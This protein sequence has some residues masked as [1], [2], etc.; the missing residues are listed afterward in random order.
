M[1]SF[2]HFDSPT[3]H[4]SQEAQILWQKIPSLLEDR[5]CREYA[6]SQEGVWFLH[7]VFLV[8][9]K[10]GGVCLWAKSVTAR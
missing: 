10:D 4:K 2:S 5:S 6:S 1:Y 7:P 8:L 9:K 3:H